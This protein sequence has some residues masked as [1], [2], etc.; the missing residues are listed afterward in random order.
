MK[1]ISFSPAGEDLR[2]VAKKI[3][4]SPGF[5]YTLIALGV[6]AR[7]AQYLANRSLWFDELM[8]A[9]NI[10]NRSYPEL[11]QPLDYVQAAPAA[12]LLATKYLCTLWGDGEM[13]LRLIPLVSGLLALA[14]YYP[15]AR[16]LTRPQA[17]LIALGLFAFSRYAIYYSAEVKQYSTDLA[18]TVLIL[19][20]SYHVYKGGYRVKNLS[21]IHI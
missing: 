7:L 4:F 5:L 13:V 15:L 19:L 14:L 2:S 1:K 21:L 12:F 9:L 10:I 6:L 3:L 8:L 20:L 18:C 11:L 16:S 17:A